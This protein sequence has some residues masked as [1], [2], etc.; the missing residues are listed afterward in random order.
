MYLPSTLANPNKLLCPVV[1]TDLQRLVNNDYGLLDCMNTLS[2]V[3]F[4]QYTEHVLPEVTRQAIKR[5]NNLSATFDSSSM[6]SE[7]LA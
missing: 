4:L 2:M 7:L 6:T 1:E 3:L 5:S